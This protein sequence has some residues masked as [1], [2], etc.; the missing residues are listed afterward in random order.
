M[1]ILKNFSVVFNSFSKSLLLYFC[2]KS[3]IFYVAS[4]CE[5]SGFT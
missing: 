5:T 3:W 4:V 2:S 1:V